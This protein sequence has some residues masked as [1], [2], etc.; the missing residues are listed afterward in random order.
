M[1]RATTRLPV[2][3]HGTKDFERPGDIHRAA[4]GVGRRQSLSHEWSGKGG[5][6]VYD[7]WG[8]L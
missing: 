3:K 7:S 6:R 8:S 5:P 1:S 4:V 2:I